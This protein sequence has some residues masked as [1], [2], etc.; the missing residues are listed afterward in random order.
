[1]KPIKTAGPSIL[2]LI[3]GACGGGGDS[4]TVEAMVCRE[5]RPEV[6]ATFQRGFPDGWSIEAVQVVMADDLQRVSDG[7]P[8]E[9]VAARVHDADG[10]PYTDT[11]V[12]W[13]IEGGTEPQFETLPKTFRIL[14]DAS[15]ELMDVIIETGL[16]RGQRFRY[17]PDATSPT[18]GWSLEHPAVVMALECLAEAP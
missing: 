5:L 16:E 3:L 9:V 6:Q 2:L 7:A 14:N 17:W 18:V 13:V 1:M 4:E 10:R 8:S 15:R 12:L 11:P